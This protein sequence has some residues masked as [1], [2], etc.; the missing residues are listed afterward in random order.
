MQL[1]AEN[2]AGEPSAYDGNRS[3][4]CNHYLLPRDDPC[5][6]GAGRGRRQAEVRPSFLKKRSKKL[7]VV[8]AAPF[9]DRA[10]PNLQKFF[11]S[12]FQKRTSLLLCVLLIDTGEK[13]TNRG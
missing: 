10:R 2:R 6:T 3:G 12:F 4:T 13:W 11:G 9:Q 8:L 5:C 1:Q 7:L